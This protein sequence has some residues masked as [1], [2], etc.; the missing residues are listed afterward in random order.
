VTPHYFEAMGIPLLAGRSFTDAET[1]DSMPV[2]I[3]SQ[4]F[5]ERYWPGQPAI[6]QRVKRGRFDSSL[7][8]MEVIGV[9]G[10]IRENPTDDIPGNDAWYLPHSQP[11]SG[12]IAEMTY[13]IKSAQ[14]A[15]IMPAVRSAVAQLD[16]DVPIFDA[17]TMDDRFARF[18]ATERLSANLTA[19][20]A[21]VG[22]FLAGVGVYAVLAFSVRR[23]LP[24]LGIR[25]ALGARPSDIRR[26]V[27]RESGFLVV[28]GVASGAILSLLVHPW[29]DANLF[30]AGVSE[31]AATVLAALGVVSVALISTIAPATRAS[32]VDPV[33][34]MA[35]G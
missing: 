16:R 6:G 11:A 27:L 8:W 1:A 12:G 20:L 4:S 32:R 33:R 7:P 29:L 10:N 13:V 19:T 21:T 3:V 15:S 18:T 26:A 23:R 31:S 9:V 25:S 14:G 5:A 22:V 35:N 28:I 2:V 17:V 24:E 30:P 34:A